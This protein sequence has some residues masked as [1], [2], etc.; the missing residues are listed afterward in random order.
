[1]YLHDNWEGWVLEIA[2][3][4]V[5]MIPIWYSLLTRRKE[6]LGPAL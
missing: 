5:P 4:L 3:K 2:M 6:A 1:M